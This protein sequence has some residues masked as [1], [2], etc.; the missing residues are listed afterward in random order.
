[1]YLRF[2]RLRSLQ[3]EGVCFGYCHHSSTVDSWLG[4]VPEVCCSRYLGAKDN[5]ETS[6]RRLT[7]NLPKS[8]MSGASQGTNS[9]H[10]EGSWTWS[11]KVCERMTLR[12]V[13]KCCGPLLK[14]LLGSMERAQANFPRL[15][16]HPVRYLPPG[17][18]ELC[19]PCR[20]AGQNPNLL[21]KTASATGIKS[22][23]RNHR[24]LISVVVSAA[25]FVQEIY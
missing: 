16:H 5:V 13:V 19:V 7:D 3:P 1:M 8:T 24:S 21:E 12:A 22:S 4:A 25:G 15:G 2:W 23:Q 10:H 9:R 11:A 6:L 14:V 18:R 20:V 17:G